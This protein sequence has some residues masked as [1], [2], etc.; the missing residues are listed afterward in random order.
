MGAD[1]VDEP[2]TLPY[3][4]PQLEELRLAVARGIDVPDTPQLKPNC[5]TEKWNMLQTSQ[6]N[7]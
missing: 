3:K 5:L 7:S 1:W 2:L 4:L 6:Q